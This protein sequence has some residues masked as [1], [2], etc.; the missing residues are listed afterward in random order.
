M[1]LPI[2]YD[3]TSKLDCVPPVLE[4]DY[5]VILNKPF[6]LDTVDWPNTATRHSLLLSYELPGDVL[7]N[8]LAEIPFTASVYYR[9][10]ISMVFQVSGTPMHQ[11]ILLASAQPL[12]NLGGSIDRINSY[13]SAPHVFLHANESTSVALEIPFY[14]NSKLAPIDFTDSTIVPSNI[15]ANFCSVELMVFNPLGVPSSGSTTVS[16]S[17]HVVFRELEFYVPHIDPEWVPFPG[18]LAEGFI[19]NFYE[20]VKATISKSLDSFA[21]GVNALAGDLLDKTKGLVKDGVSAVREGVRAYTGLHNPEIPALDGRCAVQTRQ[22]F[23]LVD[24]PNFFEKLDPYANF[25]KVFDDYYFDTDVDEMLVS[26]IISKPQF[27]GSF[28]VTSAD[29][30]GTILWSRPIS[31]AQENRV[32]TYTDAV[33]T[34]STTV[35]SNLLQTLSK[36]SR[37]WKGSINIHLQSSMTNFHFCKLIVARDYSP[38]VQMLTSYPAF[39]SVANLMTETLEFSAGGQVHTVKMPFCSPLSVL[40]CSADLQFNALQHGMYYV[41]LYQ[42]LVINGTV[43]TTIEF[44]VYVSA[45]DDFDFF[46]YSVDPLRMYKPTS[47][48]VLAL[49]DVEASSKWEAESEAQAPV[50]VNSQEAVDLSPHQEMKDEPYHMRPIKHVRDYIRRFYNVASQRVLS[51]TLTSENGCFSVPVASLL[52]LNQRGDTEFEYHSTLAIIKGL[53]LGYKGG[54]KAKLLVNGS[55]KVQV[56]YVP[57]SYTIDNAAPAGE[58]QWIRNNAIP[59]SAST[60][61][62]PIQEMFQAPNFIPPSTAIQLGLAYASQTVSVEAPNYVNNNAALVLSNGAGFSEP[63]AMSVC[64]LE[65]EIPYMS[66]FKFVGNSDLF[67]NIT[68]TDAI[69][70]LND[71]GS[72]VIKVTQPALFEVGQSTVKTGITFQLYVAATDETRLGFQINAPTIGYGSRNIP[73]IGETFLISQSSPINNYPPQALVVPTTGLYNKNLTPPDRKSVV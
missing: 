15:G 13:L 72:L 4:M 56:W 16:V 12:N 10:K 69:N 26:E 14:V 28:K 53:F 1:E 34:Q 8:A 33:G 64:E 48:P 62:L 68:S 22:N 38:D 40:P 32:Q 45:G 70:A 51:T 42:P 67:V 9:A 36:L 2:R 18:F 31:P 5:S 50:P 43:P 11:G 30:S 37:F 44:N 58:T 65:F 54:L 52:G 21:S 61:F 27:I 71:L 23:N 46:G 19:G 17:A 60:A 25:T 41:Y 24:T 66:P 39:G 20:G 57:P 35:S 3:K 29:P 47:D 49:E 63:I 6:L 55:P 7:A 59:S 73:T